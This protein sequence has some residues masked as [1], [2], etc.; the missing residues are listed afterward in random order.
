MMAIEAISNSI[1]YSYLSVYLFASMFLL[2]TWRNTPCNLLEWQMNYKM[3]D[4]VPNTLAHILLNGIHRLMSVTWT[5]KFFYF[6]FL[7]GHVVVI[8]YINKMFLCLRCAYSVSTYWWSHDKLSIQFTM[9]I[10][11]SNLELYLLFSHWE[12]KNQYYRC[13]NF[14]TSRFCA[15]SCCLISFF[16]SVKMLT[17]YIYCVLSLAAVLDVTMWRFKYH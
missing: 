9:L 1:F 14:V 2:Y 16:L 12:L 3:E 6:I 15:E 4:M 11:S 13:L 17:G 10:G 7:R 8:V 5:S